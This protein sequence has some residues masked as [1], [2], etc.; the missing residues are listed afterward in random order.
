MTQGRHVAALIWRVS[1]LAGDLGGS[2]WT[3][4]WEGTRLLAE[5]PRH[6]LDTTS[7]CLCPR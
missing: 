5:Q 7:P 1:E 4:Q 6:P 3:P 2:I